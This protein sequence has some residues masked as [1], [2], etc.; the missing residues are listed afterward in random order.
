MSSRTI[1]ASMPRALLYILCTAALFSAPLAFAG[2]AG[3][4]GGDR[5]GK[6][7]EEVAG[8]I[9]KWIDDGGPQNLQY[10]DGVTS[11]DYVARMKKVLVPTPGKPDELNG[12]DIECVGLGDKHYP[13]EVDGEAKECINFVENGRK[14]IV[15]DRQKF[16]SSLKDPDNDAGQY[17]IVHHELASLASLEPHDGPK[18]TYYYSNQISAFV[19]EKLV[20][21]LA[22][23]PQAVNV[24]LRLGKIVRGD[25]ATQRS[26]AGCLESIK[27]IRAFDDKGKLRLEM[28][29]ATCMAKNYDTY[30]LKLISADGHAVESHGFG[31]PPRLL[32]MGIKPDE[33]GKKLE[34]LFNAL[35]GQSCQLLT[36]SPDGS[37]IDNSDCHFSQLREEP[38]ES[39]E[40]AEDAA[41]AT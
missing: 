36:I 30:I 33:N 19:A 21:Y 29:D 12:F 2:G 10:R 16:Y 22:I 3:P 40:A 28:S 39:P 37:L 17:E 32:D 4:G 1:L 24:S 9:N 35:N 20:K 15:C 6:R 18:S 23:K 5:C 27:T 38:T 8:S 7:F 31:L 26:S 25:P 41:I 14:K 34:R 13:V 11:A